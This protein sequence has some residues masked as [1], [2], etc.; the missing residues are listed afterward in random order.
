M[1]DNKNLTLEILDNNINLDWHW[2]IVS[3]NSNLTF[4]NPKKYPKINYE[5]LS[6]NSNLT[7]DVVN[8]LD[9]N[10]WNFDE[11]SFHPNLSFNFVFGWDWYFLSRHPKL[12]FDIIQDYFNLNYY[13]RVNSKQ[14]WEMKGLSENPNLTIDFIIKNITEDWNWQ[15]ISINDMNISKKKYLINK[16]TKQYRKI[17]YNLPLIKDVQRVILNYLI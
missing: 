14:K 11:L 10:Y 2:K 5:Y 12:S 13:D 7:F 8:N 3:A 17:I 15:M 1:S 6:K 4:T 16:V 9:I